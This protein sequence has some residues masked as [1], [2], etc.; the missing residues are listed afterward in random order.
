MKVCKGG[1]KMAKIGKANA[2]KS[3]I[4]DDS[5]PIADGEQQESVQNGSL[6]RNAAFFTQ[7]NLSEFAGMWVCII[8]QKLVAADKDL[9]KVMEKV[10][11]SGLQGTPFITIVPSGFVTV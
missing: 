6:E 1:D 11:K 4:D 10:K 8:E 7:Q 3:V 2:K 5:I 9:K